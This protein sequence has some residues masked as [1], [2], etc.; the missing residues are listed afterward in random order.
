MWTKPST[1]PPNSICPFWNSKNGSLG[2]TNVD[3]SSTDRSL[4]VQNAHP[5]YYDPK[6][7][8]RIAGGRTTIG[9]GREGAELVCIVEVGRLLRIH[10]PEGFHFHITGPAMFGASRTKRDARSKKSGN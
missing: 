4:S 3:L 7:W 6:V 2:A 1:N 8:P 9:G 5:R 10:N